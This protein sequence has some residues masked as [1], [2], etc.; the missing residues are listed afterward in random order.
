MKMPHKPTFICVHIYVLTFSEQLGKMNIGHETS[1]VT[2]KNECLMFCNN[3][4]YI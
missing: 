1:V 4:K 3:E 2:L